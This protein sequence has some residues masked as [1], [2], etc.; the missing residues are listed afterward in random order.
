MTFV[1]LAYGHRITLTYDNGSDTIV[2]ATYPYMYID[3]SVYSPVKAWLI[4]NWFNPPANPV[5]GG[6]ADGPLVSSI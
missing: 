5:V 3:C 6:G 2:G 1:Y 4:I